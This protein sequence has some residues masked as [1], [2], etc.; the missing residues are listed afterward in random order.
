MEVG[1]GTEVA[2]ENPG[3][4]ALGYIG[5]EFSRKYVR[6]VGLISR[7]RR[8]R[9]PR[10]FPSAVPTAG[11]P[12][13]FYLEPPT[14]LARLFSRSARAFGIASIRASMRSGC[15]GW[16]ESKAGGVGSLADSNSSASST[17]TDSCGS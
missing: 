15:V 11:A 5:R 14:T 7:C 1:R 13:R 6:G 10:I 17:F 16:V 3:G 9:P 8:G 4:C 2:S 12:G